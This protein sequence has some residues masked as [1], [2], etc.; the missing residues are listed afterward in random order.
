LYSIVI[1]LAITIILI[2]VSLY[3]TTLGKGAKITLL[4]I[5]TITL[6]INLTGSL[7]KNRNN[8]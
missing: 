8:I 5:K 3:I 6:K 4:T 2:K 1:L 7:N